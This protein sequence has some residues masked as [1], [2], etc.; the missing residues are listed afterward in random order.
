MTFFDQIY[1]LHGLPETTVSDRDSL[2]LSD[3]W[4]SL[5]KLSGT[6]L[7][8]SSA[9]H[10]QTHGSTE[11]INQCLHQYLRSLTGHSPKHWGYLLQSGGIIPLFTPH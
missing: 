8:Y 1:K 2:P 10:P 5:F 9:Y 11:R 3:F 6:R 4:Q 7:L